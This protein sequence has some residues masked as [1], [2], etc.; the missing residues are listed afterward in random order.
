MQSLSVKILSNISSTNTTIESIIDAF[1]SMLNTGNRYSIEFNSV[2]NEDE[3]KSALIKSFGDDISIQDSVYDGCYGSSAGKS[4]DGF[5]VYIDS[6]LFE[7]RFIDEDFDEVINI[8]Q[9]CNEHGTLLDIDADD[10]RESMES[11]GIEGKSDN[12]YNY[13]GH[14]SY[15]PSTLCDANFEMFQTSE[16]EPVTIIVKF[17]C[18]GDPRGNYTS[19]VVYKFDDIYAAYEAFNPSLQLLDEDNLDEINRLKDLIMQEPEDKN[20]LIQ[21][22]NELIA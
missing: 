3:I 2:L 15:T 13:L 11:M 19:E 9:L 14:D 4:L 17:H 10:H 21:E 8:E 16:D 22:L 12:T 18:G 1:S 7:T 5:K 20:L 6:S